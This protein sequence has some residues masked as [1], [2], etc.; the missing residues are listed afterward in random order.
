MD[1]F[2]D[3]GETNG[4]TEAEGNDALTYAQERGLLDTAPTP[5]LWRVLIRPRKAQTTSK[6]GIVL[7]AQSRDAETHLQY[8]GQ[9]VAMG[10]MAGK[11]E[12]FGGRYDITVG[13]W[14]V[15]G[16]YA[17]QRLLHRGMRLLLVDDDQIMAKVKDQ[18]GLRVYV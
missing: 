4:W 14:V 18:D 7:A 13:D 10:P 5:T 17:G 11:S 2:R 3:F 15:Y 1:E 16:R 12:K 8:V 9:V 6:G